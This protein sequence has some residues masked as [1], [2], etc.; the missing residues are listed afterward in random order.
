[1]FRSHSG[2]VLWQKLWQC[3]GRRLEGRT[4]AGVESTMITPQTPL[5]LGSGSP[6]RREILGAL[7]LPFRVLVADTLEERQR[8]E[9][10]AQ[11]RTARCA[12]DLEPIVDAIDRLIVLTGENRRE[13][14]HFLVGCRPF[15]QVAILHCFLAIFTDGFQPR[16]CSENLL[17]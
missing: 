15:F 4:D 10:V 1:M 8:G 13:F 11:P 16:K 17:A 2:V 3:D 7:G 9:S 6:R 14:S 12:A 5:V